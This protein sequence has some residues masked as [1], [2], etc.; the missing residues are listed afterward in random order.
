MR[1]PYLAHIVKTNARL[2]E[3]EEEEEEEERGRVF[4]VL[5]AVVLAAELCSAIAAEH[6]QQ[7]I[8][9]QMTLIE[10]DGL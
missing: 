3:K 1:T 7:K 10:I 2:E 8:K 9:N 5:A 6:A 4:L